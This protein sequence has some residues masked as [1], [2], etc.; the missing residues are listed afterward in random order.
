MTVLARDPAGGASVLHLAEHL[1]GPLQAGARRLD[2]DIDAGG[3]CVVAWATR[4]PLLMIAARAD[5]AG[6]AMVIEATLDPDG[7]ARALPPVELAPWS[8]AGCFVPLRALDDD[9]PSTPL[10]VQLQVRRIDDAGG[11]EAVASAAFASLLQVV[12][13]DGQLARLL[14]VATAEKARLRREARVLAAS[15]SLATAPAAAL[16]RIGA[17]LGVA[18]FEAD[19]I[20]SASGLTTTTRREPDDEYRRRL[21]IYRRTMIPNRRSLEAALADLGP[22]YRVVE[23]D[24]ELALAFRLVETGPAGPR[25]AFLGYLRDA[26][27]IRPAEP[28]PA[29]RYLPSSLRA[30]EDALRGRLRARFELAPTADLAPPL[31]SALDR[32]GRALDALGFA[33]RLRINRAQDDAGGSRYELGLGADLAPLAAT[34]LQTLVDARRT[35]DLDAIADLD[36]RGALADAEGVDP[37]T[38]PEAGWLLRAAGLRTVHRLATGDVHVSH[39]PSF[40]LVIADGAES[41]A[42]EARYHAAGDLGGHVVLEEGLA[43]AAAEWTSGGGAPW[44]AAS[45]SERTAIVSALSEPPPAAATGLTAASL[46]VAAAGGLGAQLRQ[47][48]AAQLE[49]LRLPAALA[50]LVVAGDPAA[51]V[52]LRTLVRALTDKGLVAVLPLFRGAEVHLAVAVTS[53]PVAGANLAGRRSV[54]FRWHAVPISGAAG[55]LRAVGTVNR[56]VGE[57]AGLT[58]VVV[59]GYAR[60]GLT[61]PYELRVDPPAGRALAPRDYERLMNILDRFHPIGVEIN[62]YAIRSAHVDLD[63]DGDA[64]PL[65]PSV[66]RTF[67]PYR[68]RRRRGEEQ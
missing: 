55:T 45:T 24:N 58:A 20:G 35:V 2:V 36:V 37:A 61:D 32:L 11:S 42:L 30:R 52:P 31:A 68:I 16:D 23:E 44:V 9:V 8:E 51:V 5:L 48:P 7:A 1:A 4:A 62:T 3:R 66:A 41:G 38:D 49:F 6:D 43:S 25:A 13:V 27:L 54:G 60:R 28:V 40:G 56:L 50:A 17:D 14:H 18:R 65:P 22:G 67:R 64:E 10:V 33:P 39:L 63:G 53:L 19:L 46:P 29:H 59:L 21:A 12:V 57:A 26:V 34:D 47:V 15:R